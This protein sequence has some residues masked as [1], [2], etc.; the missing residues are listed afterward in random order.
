ML[1][2][3]DTP[4]EQRAAGGAGNLSI[5][6]GGY[7]FDSHNAQRWACRNASACY[8]TAPAGTAAGASYA[9][10]EGDVQIAP[11]LYQIPYWVT[12]PREAEAAN[13]LVVAAPSATHIGMSTLRMEPQFMMVGHAAGTAAA[14]ALSAGTS[15]QRVDTAAL[16]ARLRKERMI[17]EVPP[18]YACVDARCVLASGGAHADAGCGGE[19]A[20]LGAREWFALKGHWG[21]PSGPAGAT[22]MVASQAT[23]LKKSETHSSQLGPS[24]KLPV[25]QGATIRLAARPT[26][27]GDQYDL[28]TCAT[29]SCM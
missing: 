2:T 15:V 20:A 1:F 19:C 18:S 11:G 14:L 10:D 13:L 4:A 28:V 26:D 6:I 24:Q 27:G 21:P 5:A 17:L 29:D 25:A 8:G 3:Q 7:N 9:W 16:S 22:T 12:L 23:F